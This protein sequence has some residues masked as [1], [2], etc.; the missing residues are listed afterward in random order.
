MQQAPTLHAA[1]PGDSDYRRRVADCGIGLL[2]GMEKM[3]AAGLVLEATNTESFAE[4]P[5]KDSYQCV[6]NLSISTLVRPLSD[7]NRSDI[8][9][10][11]VNIPGFLAS[12]FNNGADTTEP[13]AVELEKITTAMHADA[14]R[15]NFDFQKWIKKLSEFGNA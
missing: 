8:S 1:N 6:I 11:L 15:A 3:H 12:R 5:K 10:N 9:V 7:S 13:A 4:I 14:L 2:R